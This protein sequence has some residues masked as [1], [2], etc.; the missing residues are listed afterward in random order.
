MKRLRSSPSRSDVRARVWAASA[1]CAEAQVATSCRNNCKGHEAEKLV[2]ACFGGRVVRAGRPAEGVVT[3]S[4]AQ[5]WSGRAT[6][7]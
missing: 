1:R 2:D 4:D 5:A 6:R 7:I 3:P